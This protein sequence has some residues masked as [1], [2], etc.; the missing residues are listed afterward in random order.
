VV[1]ELRLGVQTLCRPVEDI[2][3]RDK[4]SKDFVLELHPEEPDVSSNE[5]EREREKAADRVVGE[6]W[7]LNFEIAEELLDIDEGSGGGNEIEVEEGM[8]GVSCCS[9]ND[10]DGDLADG[11]RP[12]LIP[13]DLGSWG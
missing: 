4:P 7:A 13:F 12:E 3:E 5:V 6:G 8:S 9:A 2:P 1:L 11:V 10:G